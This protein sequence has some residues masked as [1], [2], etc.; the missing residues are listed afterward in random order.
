MGKAKDPGKGNRIIGTIIEIKG[1]CS[2]GHELGD[3]FKLSCHSSEGLCGF[4]TTSFS[5]GSPLC[6]LGGDIP[7]GT[8]D[9]LPLNTNVR[10]KRTLLH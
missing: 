6:S 7:G 3:R 9:R 4:F 8:R 10:I 5:R 2:V 1:E